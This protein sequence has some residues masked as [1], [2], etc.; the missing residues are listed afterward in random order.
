MNGGP[1]Y[2]AVPMTVV[3]KTLGELCDNCKERA[4]RTL[5]EQPETVLERVF[6]ENMAEIITR[7][8][9]QSGVTVEQIQAKDNSV[10]IVAVRRKI[11]L[12]ARSKHYSFPQIGAALRRHHTTIISLVQSKQKK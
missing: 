5:A 4:R 11:A 2:R 7:V 6:R 3:L 12:E 1:E 9:Q 10:K 8:C